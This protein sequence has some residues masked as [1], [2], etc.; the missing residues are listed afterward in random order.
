MTMTR[1]T[2]VFNNA[3][4]LQTAGGASREDPF[5][6][7]RTTLALGAEASF[8][9]Q[10]SLSHHP[11]GQIVGRLHPRIVHKR[12]QRVPLIENAAALARQGLAAVGTPGQQ[13][14][15]LLHQWLHATLKHW[16]AKRAIPYAFAGVQRAGQD[17]DQRQKSRSEVPALDGLG[18]RLI[19]Q[20]AAVPATIVSCRYS[21]TSGRM[22]GTSTIWCRSGS[23][24]VFSRCVPPHRQT[25][26][27][28]SIRRVTASSGNNA[29]KCGG[30][31]LAGSAFPA[32]SPRQGHKCARR[33]GRRGFGR[34][35][36]IHT[37]PP[38]E[39]LNM[40]LHLLKTLFQRFDPLFQCG[41][42][43]FQ[44]LNIHVPVHTIVIG[45]EQ[46]FT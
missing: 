15:H 4:S 43:R 21:M 5:D 6:I 16:P 42:F 26:G 36:R 20:S 28:T 2:Q 11:L 22:G 40:L 24:V 46:G 35:L 3:S 25:V 33:I 32:L 37:Q 30:M 19:H 12:P 34:I 29:R 7:P 27:D 13:R 23:W 10:D 41:V 8:A 44:L 9:P 38:F 39:I 45:H 1:M 17:A 14:L 18:Q 31:A